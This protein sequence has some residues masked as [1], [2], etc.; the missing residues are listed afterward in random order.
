MG[1]GASAVATA[2]TEELR[3]ASDSLSPEL[4]QKIL[5]ALKMVEAERDGTIISLS[6]EADDDPEKV[7]I[8]AT[9]DET[10]RT[11]DPFAQSISEPNAIE[12]LVG[13]LV[14]V[15]G[16]DSAKSLAELLGDLLP[17]NALEQ[18]PTVLINIAFEKDTDETVKILAT[19]GEA[20]R[21]LDPF[22]VVLRDP[23]AIEKRGSNDAAEIFTFFWGPP[24]P[25][26]K[27]KMRAGSDAEKSLADLA[28]TGSGCWQATRDHSGKTLIQLELV[29]ST[30]LLGA[31]Q[32]G[33]AAVVRYLCEAKAQFEKNCVTQERET[34]LMSAVLRNHVEVVRALCDA[35]ANPL[36]PAAN[37][38]T[39]L[40]A[41]EIL[42]LQEIV[43]IMQQHATKGW[44]RV[45]RLGCCR[46]AES[47]L[48][49]FRWNLR[50]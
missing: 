50:D 12:K 41:A 44:R 17:G 43:S 6:F 24:R 49:R 28:G 46:R 34:C 39:P 16:P 10:K 29:G 27:M 5:T 48:W 15:E 25:Q 3:E 18:P 26:G 33:H 47:A 45:F 14:Q 37:G 23:N 13:K 21:E 35:G 2:S 19:V 31:V 11:L 20:E 36:Y 42:E 40:F 1:G 9:V 22:T 4:R 7:K 30:P 32:A 38:A 8:F